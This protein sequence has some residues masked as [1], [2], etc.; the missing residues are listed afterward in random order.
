MQWSADRNAGFSRANPQRLY[1]P[2]I[3]DPEYHYEAVNVEAQQGNSS[4][5]LWWNKR[6]IHLRQQH[7]AFSHGTIEFLDPHN[8][9]ILVFLRRYQE[10]CVMVV[11]NMSR[12]VQHVEL[13]LSDF[14]GIVPVEL[15][16]S[17]AF[18]RIT[19]SSYSLTLGPHSFYW[20]SLNSAATLQPAM[21]PGGRRR[22]IPALTSVSHWEQL[23]ERTHVSSLRDIVRLYLSSLQMGSDTRRTLRD[24]HIR[25]S[26][27][28]ASEATVIRLL[29]VEAEFNTSDPETFV[30]RCAFA[31]DE[32]W[33][34]SS[35]RSMAD[36]IA[37]IEGP[38]PGVIYSAE[39]DPVLL[40]AAIGGLGG[41]RTARGEQ[42][43]ELVAWSIP[44]VRAE[45]EARHGIRPF[46]VN[47]NERSNQSIAFGGRWELKMFR[48]VEEGT[49]PEIDLGRVLSEHTGR[50]LTPKLL[51]GIEYRKRRAEPMTM[52]VLHEYVPHESEAWSYA[53]DAV[54]NFLDRIVASPENA[55]KVPFEAVLNPQ[56]ELPPESN[57][58]VGGF[59]EKAAL[60]GTRLAEL[61]LV[62]AS[63][64][65][66]PEIAPEAFSMQY[67]RGIY[68]TMRS[69][70]RDLVDLLFHQRE[71]LSPEQQTMAA[72]ILQNDSL[73]LKQY[74]PLL[75]R[76]FHAK[77]TRCHGNCHLGHVLYTGNDFVFFDFEGNPFQSLGQRRI[78]RSPFR[79]VASMLRSIDF[80]AQT[81]LLGLN[82]GRGQPQGVIR[83]ADRIALEPWADLWQATAGRRFL[84]AYLSMPEITEIIPENTDDQ[85]LL[86]RIFH[87]KQL[88][89]ELIRELQNPT[90]LVS[91]P[92]RRVSSFLKG[93]REKFLTPPDPTP[94]ENSATVSAS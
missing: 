69:Q 63:R 70:M 71:S 26:F 44:E 32:V 15:F 54:S 41:Q 85:Y 83:A 62:L 88:I 18:P 23:F 9:K 89:L 72:E 65:D 77:R 92:L 25:D 29:L 42:G 16:G 79:D 38:N 37:R 81:T 35:D 17:T 28:F 6:L 24:V 43:G 27:R 84:Q 40:E 45:L 19:K 60:M 61:H 57:E 82:S 51:G 3:I 20:F 66:L 93:E 91:I 4:S 30:L 46:A 13:N 67:Q 14:D 68:Q 21:T 94:N 10:E 48:R 90:S 78:K 8:R 56:M 73:L 47:R 39:L 34:Q 55:P 53:Q 22:T 7:L 87:Q 5:L 58:W 33:N 1:L 75:E 59:F 2:I 86:L 49:H 50:R 36:V 52:A 31:S 76:P 12:F 74:R 64:H 11:A 80:A